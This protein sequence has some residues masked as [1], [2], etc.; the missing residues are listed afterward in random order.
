MYCPKC[1]KE[2]N[3][4]AKF[5]SNCGYRIKKENMDYKTK[6]IDISTIKEVEKIPNF[7]KKELKQ[8]NNNSVIISAGTIIILLLTITLLLVE[9][10][11]NNYLFEEEKSQYCNENQDV[12]NIEEEVK[13]EEIL[14]FEAM[15]FST[16]DFSTTSTKQDFYNNVLNI[17]DSKSITGNKYCNNE[18]YTQASNKINNDLDLEYSYLC[19]MDLTY[20]N[21]LISRLDQFYEQNNINDKI[22]DAYIVGKGGRN[23]YANYTG[24]TIGYNSSYLAYLRRVH[25]SISLF[26]DYDKLKKT[27]ERDL[28]SGFHPQNST[29]ED[30]IVHE[31]AHALDFYISAKKYHID[32]LVIDDFNKYSEFY[33]IWANQSYA[34]EV[35]LK[36]VEK[37]NANYQANN[38]PTKTEEEL[39]LEISGYAN[40]VNNGVVMYAETFAEALV[41]YL[42]NGNNASDLSIEI[43]KIVQEDLITL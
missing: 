16:Y 41:D 40:I 29:P 10:N 35:V 32:S 1:G 14:Y 36:A 34:K 18:N 3:I 39:K 30:I 11:K 19:G 21:N 38:L 13:E 43:Y 24:Q 2:L 9:R 25:M 42:S 15:D 12:C 17:L 33:T 5:C 4:N 31:T 27:Y 7:N 20:I 26:S 6:E 23:E 37:V 28:K 8:H 22:V